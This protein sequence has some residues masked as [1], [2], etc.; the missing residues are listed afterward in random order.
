MAVVI[1][2]FMLFFTTACVCGLLFRP[3][4]ASRDTVLITQHNVLQ[5]IALHHAS[6]LQAIG[7]A[8]HCCPNWGGAPGQDRGSGVV[9][10]QHMPPSPAPLPPNTSRMTATVFTSPALWQSATPSL[11][12]DATL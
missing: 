7:L 2:L 1:I 12:V 9:L 5:K 10:A 8:C 3:A 4:S 6:L 11:L